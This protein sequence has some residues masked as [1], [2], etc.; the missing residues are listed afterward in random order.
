MMPLPTDVDSASRSA[1]R[2]KKRSNSTAKGSDTR[3]TAWVLM[4]TTLGSAASTAPTTGVRRNAEASRPAS[5][6]RLQ[7]SAAT[8][9]KNLGYPLDIRNLLCLL[10]VVRY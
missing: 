10:K 1:C 6:P 3:I 8:T 7:H 9:R 2:A 4:L 5:S